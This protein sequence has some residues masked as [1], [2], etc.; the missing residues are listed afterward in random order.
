MSRQIPGQDWFFFGI[1][2]DLKGE[3]WAL[4]FFTIPTEK[5]LVSRK[6]SKTRSW[7]NS[8]SK[9]LLERKRNLHMLSELLVK[10]FS[11]ACID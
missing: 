6:N 9:I 4:I 8:W 3:P 10:P 7:S 5:D 2:M 1:K 11:I